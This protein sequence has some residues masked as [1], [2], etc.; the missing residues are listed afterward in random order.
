M[1]QFIENSAVYD[2]SG[3]MRE[4]LCEALSKT[5]E[6]VYLIVPDQFEFE[7]EKTVYSDLEK[8]GLLTELYRVNVTT[9][10]SRAKICRRQTIR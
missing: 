8:N 7:T 9:F 2:V 4:K 6:T 1:I 5:E 10:T 3:K